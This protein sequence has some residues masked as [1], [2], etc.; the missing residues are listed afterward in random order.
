MM[1][2]CDIETVGL[3]NAA[4]FLPEPE[5]PANYKDPE[6]IAA[7]IAE[8]RVALLADAAL[9]PT[10]NR[11][12]SIGWVD[13]L[14]ETTVMVC[15]D[16]YVER[17]ALTAFWESRNGRDLVGFNCMAFD[18]PTL[19]L[20][21]MFLKVEPGIRS[22]NRFRHDGI[23]DLM[24]FLS[25]DGMLKFKSLSWWCDRFGIDVP[26]EHDGKAIAGLVEAGN[27]DAVAA[28]NRADVEKTRA[29]AFRVGVGW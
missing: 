17:S 8:K 25:F 23:V 22:L 12:V 4:A 28:H 15:P 6:K 24:Q 26:D 1:R 14:G 3:P 11:I 5:A 21:S 16:E 2:F 13:D 29:L 27:W 20:R 9:D 7:Y 18:L 10:L 19:V